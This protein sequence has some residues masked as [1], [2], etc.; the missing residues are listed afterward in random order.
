MQR[1][2]YYSPS[3]EKE[4][5]TTIVKESKRYYWINIFNSIQRKRKELVE[6]IDK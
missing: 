1:A 2:T 6:K 5:Q 4:I 3:H